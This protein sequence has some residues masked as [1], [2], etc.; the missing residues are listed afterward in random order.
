MARPRS[1]STGDI[2]FNFEYQPSQKRAFRLVTRRGGEYVQ[3]AAPQNLEI[4][5]IRSG[6]TVGRLMYYVQNYCLKFPKCNILVLRRTFSELDAGAIQD[7]KTFEFHLVELPEGMG[8][9]IDSQDLLRL[10]SRK[11][12]VRLVDFNDP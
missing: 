4:G 9:L 1:T 6:K 12:K 11:H 5:G 3:L 10:C 7:F 2:Q 8:F